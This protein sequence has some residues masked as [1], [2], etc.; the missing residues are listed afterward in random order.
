M[1]PDPAREPE[2]A[3]R[4]LLGLG[5]R[6]TTPG[7]LF[8]SSDA[9]VLFIARWRTELQTRFRF[10]LPADDVLDAMVNK[11]RQYELAE[12]VHLPYAP[13]FY[14][15]TPADVQA[16]K[17]QLIYPAIVKPYFGHLWRAHFGP[18][19]KGFKVSNAAE[20]VACFEQVFPAGQ[21]ALVQ[22][23]ILGPN[24]N[25]FKVCAYMSQSG[26]PLALFTLRKIRQYPAEFGVGTLVES[27]AYPELAELGRRFFQEIGYRGIGS[28][29]FKRDERDGQLKLIELNP[30]LWHQNSQAD[31]CGQNF[32]WIQYL[33]L[34]GRPPAPQLAFT[35]GVKWWNAR[36][37]FQSFLEY[38]RRGELSLAGWVSSWL[39]ARS[40]ATFALDDLGPFWRA[41]D[42]GAGILK[43]PKFFRRRAAR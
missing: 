8:P 18:S 21:P 11:R 37:D 17:D 14:P 38:S 10:A 32:P 29:E 31:D 35:P 23:V 9:F 42:Y 40:F 5:E 6:L 2:A 24:T 3:L 7:L 30:R 27:L 41:Y 28:I 16:I 26:E 1:C 15:E 20:L 33:D 39:G 19:N 43:L 25:H 12:R 22:S 36:H 13:T 4:F 34:T